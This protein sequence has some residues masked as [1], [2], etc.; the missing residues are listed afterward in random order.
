M[1]YFSKPIAIHDLDNQHDNEINRLR[2]DLTS[3]TQQCMKLEEANRAWQN[4]QYEQIERCRQ[5]L[6]PNIPS[7]E[8]TEYTSLEALIQSVVRHIDQLQIEKQQILH[9]LNSLKD[10]IRLNT[11][12]LGNIIIESINEQKFKSFFN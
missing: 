12:R 5:G 2:Q 1:F 10:N 8:S 3:A 4:Y 6:Q 11:Q 7:L 9:E